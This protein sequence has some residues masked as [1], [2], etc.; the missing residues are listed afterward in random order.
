MEMRTSVYGQRYLPPIRIICDLNLSS[1]KFDYNETDFVEF[2]VNSCE[3]I[4]VPLPSPRLIIP[5][6]VN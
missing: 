1:T 3:S 6:D 2:M 5:G 4:L